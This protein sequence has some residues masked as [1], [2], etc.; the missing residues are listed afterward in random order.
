MAYSRDSIQWTLFDDRFRK[1]VHRNAFFYY[2]EILLKKVF[3]EISFQTNFTPLFLVPFLS[4]F[5]LHCKIYR[6]LL[7]VLLGNFSAS[8]RL[9]AS[10]LNHRAQELAMTGQDRPLSL[11]PELLMLSYWDLLCIKMID[12]VSFFTKNPLRSS[13]K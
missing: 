2:Q 6:I 3:F 7:W 8:T 9:D 11:T 12:S 13:L 1:I 5:L 10:P 4:A